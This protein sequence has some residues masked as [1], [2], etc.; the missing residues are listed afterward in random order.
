MREIVRI[1]A[2]EVVPAPEL[3][4]G[5]LGLPAGTPADARTQEA[6]R[7][8]CDLLRAEARPVGLAAEIGAADFAAVYRGEGRNAPE[9]PLATIFPRATGLTLF[10]VTIGEGVGRRIAADFAGREFLRA[11]ALDAAASEAVELAADALERRLGSRGS[12]GRGRLRYSPG[13]CGWHLSG[14]RA[15]FAALRPEAIGVRLRES[16]LMEPL[17]SMSGVIVDGAP[18]IH[19]FADGYPFCGECRT[20]DCRERIARVR[21]GGKRPTHGHPE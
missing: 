3:I 2:A 10:A 18:E 5:P 12:A 17:K 21:E 20:R 15:L 1:D 16:M 9:T 8:A 13:Y 6:I 19:V 4:A 7:E 14:Q 11:T